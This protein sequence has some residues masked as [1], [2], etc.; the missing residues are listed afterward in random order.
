MNNLKQGAY[1]LLRKSENVFKTD[2][3]YVAK[4]GGLLIGAQFVSAL[5]G[6]GLAIIFA[7]FTS[8]ETYGT[9]KYILSVAGIIGALTLSGM[10]T[11]IV[12]SVAQGYEG[13]FKKGFRINLKWNIVMF[14][15]AIIAGFYYFSHNNSLLGGCLMIIALTYPVLNAA[16]IY[17][18]YLNGKKEYKYSAYLQLVRNIF[19]ILSVIVCVLLTKNIFLIIS[20]YL[21]SSALITYLLMVLVIRK[22]QPNNLDDGESYN[23]AKHLSLMGLLTPVSNQIDSVLLFHFLGAVPVAIYALAVSFPDQ[24]IGYFKNIY[25]LTLPKYSEKTDEEIKKTLFKKTL[26]LGLISFIIF[27]IYV[28]FSPFLFSLFFPKYID[29]VRFSQI[30]GFNIVLSTLGLLPAAY[31]DSQLEKKK[32]YIVV[33]A[34]NVIKISGMFLLVVPFGI[35]GII[36]AEMLARLVALIL[37]FYLIY[38]IKKEAPF[39][40][41]LEEKI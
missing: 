13:L 3:V 16:N 35:M 36:G 30:F 18:P 41:P 15:T 32:K 1:N 14:L 6:L 21:I 10:N 20:T 33:V 19:P 8:K 12:R 2:M 31:F 37:M 9:Y 29:S 17:N 7:N 34:T 4:G 28:I 5:A 11:A 27:L 38:Y 24:I 22:Y 25:S 23:Y 26:I 40:G 39:T